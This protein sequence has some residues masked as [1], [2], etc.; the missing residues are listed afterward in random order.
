MG[1]A[2]SPLFRDGKLKDKEKVRDLAQGN[3]VRENTT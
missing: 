1:L 2:S 3:T